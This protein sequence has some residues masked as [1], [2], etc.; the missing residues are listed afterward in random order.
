MD[1]PTEES[2]CLPSWVL[3]NEEGRRKRPRFLETASAFDCLY[4]SG[5]AGLEQQ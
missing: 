2:S 5:A 3:S 1:K 4:G